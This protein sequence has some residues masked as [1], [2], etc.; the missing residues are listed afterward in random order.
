[1]LKKNKKTLLVDKYLYYNK[2]H[3]DIVILGI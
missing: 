2:L 1:M 3:S